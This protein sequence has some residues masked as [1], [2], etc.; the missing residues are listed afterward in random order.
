MTGAR[1]FFA[2][3]FDSVD[4]PAALRELILAA[5]TEPSRHWHGPL[6]HALMLRAVMQ[7]R[8]HRSERR[9]LIL[10]TLFHDIVYDA[11]RDDN[12]AASA[13]LAREWLSGVEADTVAAMIMAT[14]GH[15]LADVDPVTRTLLLADLGILWTPNAALY[16][17]YA[18]GIR[19]EYRDVPIEAYRAGRSKVLR[20]IADALAPHLPLPDAAQLDRN[21]GGEIE[22]LQT[23][24]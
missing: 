21:V 7:T 3:F 10:A 15:D 11:H 17:F 1:R 5:L 23:D 20:V 14:R 9:L 4:A 2:P 8:P 16:R 18:D 22:R 24:R 19:A 6:H 12:E 13:A